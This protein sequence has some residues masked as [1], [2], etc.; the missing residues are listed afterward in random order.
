M[1]FDT[2]YT[3]TSEIFQGYNRKKM[4]VN[5]FKKVIIIAINSINK[6]T[7]KELLFN[8]RVQSSVFSLQRIII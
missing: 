4:K 3:I 1:E 6:L 7:Y 5:L 2:F 8:S